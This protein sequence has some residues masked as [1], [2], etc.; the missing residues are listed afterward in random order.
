MARE[1]FLLG[2]ACTASPCSSDGLGD[3]LLGVP[4]GSMSKMPSTCPSLCGVGP[5]PLRIKAGVGCSS[6]TGESI[7]GCSCVLSSDLKALPRGVVVAAFGA[8]SLSVFSGTSRMRELFFGVSTGAGLAYS[9]YLRELKRLYLAAIAALLLMSSREGL[10]PLSSLKVFSQTLSSSRKVL[11]S[12]AASVDMF[13]VWY[14][15][16]EMRVLG[17]VAREFRRETRSQIDLH[18]ETHALP[19]HGARMWGR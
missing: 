3:R 13:Y 11:V 7:G 15:V 6:L 16:V 18:H 1:E 2:V 14:C 17:L 9:G 8:R 12:V 19:K 10:R 4:F 5:R